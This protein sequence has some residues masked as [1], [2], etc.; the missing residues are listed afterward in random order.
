[1]LLFD[2]GGGGCGDMEERR[3]EDYFIPKLNDE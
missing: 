2:S 3:M 1:M